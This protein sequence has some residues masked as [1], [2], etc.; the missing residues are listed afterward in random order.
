MGNTRVRPPRLELA[1]KELEQ[2]L[3]VIR[4]ALAKRPAQ[5]RSSA[6]AGV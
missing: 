4:E 3:A 6:P 5:H 1:G 2:T